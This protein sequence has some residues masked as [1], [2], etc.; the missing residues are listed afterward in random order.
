[1]DEKHICRK[2]G[3]PV[4]ALDG[5]TWTDPGEIVKLA[6]EEHW[7]RIMLRWRCCD[8][9]DVAVAAYG[10]QEAG[11]LR[12]QPVTALENAWDAYPSNLPP[13]GYPLP[14]TFP[15]RGSTPFP[16]R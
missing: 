10:D 5:P 8:S 6:D 1:M 15:A 11:V 4:G 7:G 13:R 14:R 9:Y 12:A 3:K 16:G 2:G